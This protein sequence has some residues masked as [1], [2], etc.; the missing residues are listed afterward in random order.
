MTYPGEISRSTK[1]TALG[2][3]YVETVVNPFG[4]GD[5]LLVCVPAAVAD[6]AD[7][8]VMLCAHG[9]NGSEQTINNPQ[10]L[11]T[12]DKALDKGWLVISAYA[13]GNAWANDTALADYARIPT[14]VGQTWTIAHLLLHG[15]SMGALTMANFYSR[16]L[17]RKIRGMVGIDGAYNLAQAYSQSAYRPSIRA[18]YGIASDGSDYAAKTAGHDATLLPPATF[19]GRR[20]FVSASP[21]DVAIPKVSHSDVFVAMLGT[22]PADLEVVEGT[23]GHVTS[24]NYF[25]SAAHAFF[26]EA[27]ANAVNDDPVEPLWPEPIPFPEGIRDVT[28]YAKAGGE[29]IRLSV[30][31]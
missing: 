22:E 27:I 2:T 31:A 25:P 8:T 12:R 26:D 16:R 4:S 28:L 9:H 11:S 21:A 13:H 14:W 5:S 17:A 6:G 10:M 29:W 24:P 20:L 3:S 7:V 18:A 23:G 15:Q 1:S 19:T 30:G